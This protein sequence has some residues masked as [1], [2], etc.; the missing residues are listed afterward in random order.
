MDAP[1]ETQTPR[2]HD[3][4][5]VDGEPDPASPPTIVLARTEEMSPQE[6]RLTRRIAYRDRRLGELLVPADPTTFVTDLTSVPSVFAWLVPRTGEHLPAALLHDGL[7]GST[8]EHPTYLS[9]EGHVV[10]AE[11]ANRVFR[12]AMADT[13]T[14]LLRRWL[15]WTAVTLATMITG[16]GTSWSTV[17]RWR[18]RLT[19]V[20]TLLVVT[21]LGL[22]A[23]ADLVDADLPFVGGVPWMGEG[24]WWARL[25][26][27]AAGAVVI[28][29]VLGLAWG[30]F[31]TAGIITGIGLALLLHVTAALA[32]L[33]GLYHLIE[34]LSARTPVLALALA[35]ALTICAAVVVVLAW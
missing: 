35:G 9:A 30:R 12:D 20:G 29:L 8:P 13:G 16:A 14:A 2:F 26:S 27:G 1:L 7:I 19:A 18:W 24:A 22:L 33:T 23:T 5:P 31:R 21:V 34:W 6:F 11:A 25:L 10:D 3:G 15:M 17:E 4:G 32:L 28:P